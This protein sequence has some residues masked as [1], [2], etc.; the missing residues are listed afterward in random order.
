[1]EKGRDMTTTTFYAMTANAQLAQ[2][3]RILDTHIT[4]SINGHCLG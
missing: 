3:R 1:M 2:A 4:S